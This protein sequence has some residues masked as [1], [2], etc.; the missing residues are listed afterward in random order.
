M[1]LN[2]GHIAQF[3]M[4]LY[5]GFCKIDEPANGGLLLPGVLRKLK[6][7][8]IEFNFVRSAFID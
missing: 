7:L 8:D 2:P 6:D 1:L 5:G 3:F 4:G